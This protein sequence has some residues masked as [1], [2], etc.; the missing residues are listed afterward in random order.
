[1]RIVAL[2]LTLSIAACDSSAA[3]DPRLD[4]EWVLHLQTIR[5]ANGFLDPAGRET[6]GRIIISENI[7][8]YVEDEKDLRPGHFRIVGRHFLD[9]RPL[10][11][12][13]DALG[14][15]PPS[16]ELNESILDD[17]FSYVEG[18][19]SD[20]DEVELVLTPYVTHHG[21]QLR[22]QLRADTIAGE[23]LYYGGNPVLDMRGTF[24][25][26]RIERSELWNWTLRRAHR[27]ARAS[28][29]AWSRAA[30]E[31]A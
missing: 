26:V 12:S 13:A 28:E 20:D 6:S 25:M 19:I 14:K 1:M 10:L 3:R 2:L 17:Y 4:G 15:E 31:G 24:R 30:R 21:T 16:A 7:P 23:W 27:A 18:G 22:G 29:R 9:I 11:L 8:D 5:L